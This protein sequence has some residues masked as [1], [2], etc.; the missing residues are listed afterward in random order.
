MSTEP[1][2]VDAHHHLWDL[3]VRDQDWTR[4]IPVL[5]RTFGMD[6]LAPAL[7]KHAISGTVLVQTVTVADETPEMLALA[8]HD[9][10]ILG[11]VGWVDLTAGDVAE[12]IAELVEAPV[13]DRLVGIRHQVQLEP[14]P[15][16]LLRDDVR[17][18]LAAVADAGLVY[19]LLVLPHQL[20]SAVDVIETVPD[21]TWVLDHAGKPPIATGDLCAWASHLTALARHQQV[22]CKL[23]GLVTEAPE[24]WAYDDLARCAETVLD[25]FGADRVMFGSDWPVCLIR[26]DYDEV[27][28]LAER[29]V[30]QLADWEAEAFWGGTAQRWYELT[31]R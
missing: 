14:D 26:C 23:S 2:R 16:W 30:D 18:G 15:A 9:P 31:P 8:A 22:A 21:L 3:A 4:E 11:V 12:R 19:E 28:D 7:G 29:F 17:R 13:G 27:V 10:R 5:R 25:G 6:D 24:A 20:P 1:L